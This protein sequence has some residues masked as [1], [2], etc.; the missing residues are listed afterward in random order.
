MGIALPANTGYLDWRNY[1]GANA[2]NTMQDYEAWLRSNN[3][4]AQDFMRLVRSQGGVQPSDL[5]NP[6]TGLG[7]P[8]P[9]LSSI[10]VPGGAAPTTGLGGLA[11]R[12]RDQLP[13]GGVPALGMPGGGLGQPTGPPMAGPPQYLPPTLQLPAPR[14]PNMRGGWQS[15]VPLDQFGGPAGPD[16]PLNRTGG[17][18]RPVMP[19]I[20]D[21]AMQTVLQPFTQP[22]WGLGQVDPRYLTQ[23]MPLPGGATPQGIVM[24]PQ[25][26]G[27]GGGA[28]ALPPPA[29]A[30]GLGMTIPIDP[31]LTGGYV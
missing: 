22:N 5:I 29:M 19:S 20:R 18:G 12:V 13:I 1:I 25:A 30:G 23:Q 7:N 2:P 8:S 9:D 31:R 15:A 28:V 11:G 6:L 24:A 27:G 3:M 21:R 26:G 10:P 14:P 16:I 17:L 4:S